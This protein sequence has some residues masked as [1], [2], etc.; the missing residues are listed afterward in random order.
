MFLRSRAIKEKQQYLD[1]INVVIS[2]IE[3][4]G[5]FKER[6]EEEKE[7]NWKTE[8]TAINDDD[9]SRVLET[10]LANTRNR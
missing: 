5:K 4:T 3:Q 10:D 6:S 2:K 8:Q 9:R 7:C 1:N